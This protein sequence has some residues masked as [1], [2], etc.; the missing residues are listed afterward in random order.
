MERGELGRVGS[1]GG[2]GKGFLLIFF[3]LIQ[4]KNCSIVLI[5]LTR[6]Y[7]ISVIFR[8]LVNRG[9]ILTVM[10]TNRYI[11]FLKFERATTVAFQV[12]IRT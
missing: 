1:R 2:V 6:P 9:S 10:Q 3:Y 8:C 5:V 12:R 7:M 4:A 11:K